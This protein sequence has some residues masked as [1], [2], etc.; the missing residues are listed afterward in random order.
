VWVSGS[1]LSEDARFDV[2]PALPQ[3]GAALHRL[4]HEDHELLLVG[5]AGTLTDRIRSEAPHVDPQHVVTATQQLGDLLPL[6][7]PEVLG[8]TPRRPT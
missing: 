7:V 5:L 3:R 4:R 1:R 6:C 8:E 2:H